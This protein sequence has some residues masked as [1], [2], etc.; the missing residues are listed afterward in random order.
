MKAKLIEIRFFAKPYKA[1]VYIAE[2]DWILDCRQARQA[3]RVVA[4]T[5]VLLRFL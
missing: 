3:A 2:N 1:D 5:S 4:K